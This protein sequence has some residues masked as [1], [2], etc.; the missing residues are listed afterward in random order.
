[1]DKLVPRGIGGWLLIPTIV[2]IAGTL[3]FGLFC[4]I[5]LF[6]IPYEESSYFSWMFIFFLSL[7]IIWGRT[8][9]LEFKKSSEFPK[10]MIFCLWISMPII[11]FFGV[12]AGIEDFNL[13]ISD[14]ISG[15]ISTA[16]WSIYFLKSKRVNNTFYKDK[17]PTLSKSYALKISIISLALSVIFI[18]LSPN[19]NEKIF[20]FNH[21]FNTDSELEVF[22]DNISVG[23]TSNNNFTFSILNETPSV[24][25]ISGLYNN[26][27]FQFEYEFPQDYMNYSVI[28][29][30][31]LE[32]YVKY[33]IWYEQFKKEDSF[34]T[35]EPHWSHMPL[36][37]DASN[38]IETFQGKMYKDIIEAM[39]FIENR[40]NK[41]ITFEQSK[42]EEA[43]ITFTCDIGGVRRGEFEI[44][45][46]TEA[47][48]LLSSINDTNVF[49]QGSV[50][51][52]ST[53]E[54]LG[55]RPVLIIHEILHLFGIE[56]ADGSNSRDIMNEFDN[57][58]CDN[59][60]TQ[61][62]MSYLIK[63]YDKRQ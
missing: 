12:V 27:E 36:T 24:V 51:I 40:T 14:L 10:E 39:N 13:E 23:F 6:S 11:Y 59:D 4:I 3:L 53:H 9:I 2:L 35:E 58:R 32:K 61:K 42:S 63:L 5:A 62:D 17:K 30:D 41:I 18:I 29:F 16:I 7:T 22:F 54:C 31:V 8:I 25:K 37:W 57:G 19:L 52:Y 44:G 1:M 33:Y 34:Y 50:Y 45:F 47:D 60:I 56:H 20:A 55:K 43:D 15:A 28:N 46:Y 48:A 26:K 49:G 38:C 21:N